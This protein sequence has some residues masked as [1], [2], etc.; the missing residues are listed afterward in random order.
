MPRFSYFFAVFHV[1]FAVVFYFRIFWINY[2]KDNDDDDHALR[3]DRNDFDYR[4]STRF[5]GIRAEADD[6]MNECLE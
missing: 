6:D 3:D 4:Y 1:G 5:I 2:S